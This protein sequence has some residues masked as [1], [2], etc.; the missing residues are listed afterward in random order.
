MTGRFTHKFIHKK[1][2]I[3]VGKYTSPIGLFLEIILWSK[4]IKKTAQKATAVLESC[5]K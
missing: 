5:Q 1:S 2:T 3:H 4:N